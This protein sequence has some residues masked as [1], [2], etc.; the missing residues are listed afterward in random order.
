MS[1]ADG[2]APRTWL[3]PEVWRGDLLRI[4]LRVT[5][6]L[7]VFV[8]VPSAWF[9]LQTDLVGV[10]VLDTVAIATVWLMVAFEGRSLF[11]RTV[12]TLAVFYSL[13]VGLLMG[14]GPI[15]QIYLF[16]FSLLVTLLLGLRW[17]MASVALNAVTLLAVGV[18]DLAAPDM[19]V[20]GMNMDAMGWTLVSANF[21]L[22]NFCVALVLGAVIEA[23]ETA[24]ARSVP[25]PDRRPDRSPWGLAR[26]GHRARGRLVGGG[27]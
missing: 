20:P 23:L 10:F 12:V 16:G 2:M 21:V 22:V 15:S 13:G 5:A 26:R 19:A 24:L 8:Y 3:R 1:L 18:A 14:V 4:V 7:G 6:G 17:G 27:P 9:S 25:A 11:G